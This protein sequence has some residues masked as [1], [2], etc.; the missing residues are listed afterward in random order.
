MPQDVDRYGLQ[1]LMEAGAQVV[2]VL[3][4]TEYEEYHLPGAIHISLKRLTREAVKRLDR[5]RA[6]V[7]YCN[8]YQ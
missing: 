5:A 7:V 6:V 1:R 4:R 8:D 3:P 2:D